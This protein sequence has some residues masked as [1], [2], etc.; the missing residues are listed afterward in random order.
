MINIHCLLAIY[1]LEIN[2]F[3]IDFLTAFFTPRVL[4]PQRS[5]CPSSQTLVTKQKTAS[6]PCSEQSREPG[7][8]GSDSLHT[9]QEKTALQGTIFWKKAPQSSVEYVSKQ[10]GCVHF[11]FKQNI[12]T[13]NFGTSGVTNSSRSLPGSINKQNWLSVR[14]SLLVGTSGKQRIHLPS[15]PASFYHM[16]TWAKSC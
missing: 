5:H 15:T 9:V 14:H 6:W 8:R 4:L 16:G 10:M 12:D 2:H 3:R 13:M 1:C 7:V 11:F